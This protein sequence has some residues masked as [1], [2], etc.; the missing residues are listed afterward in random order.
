MPPSLVG[1]DSE[2]V[3]SCEA[4]KAMRSVILLGSALVSLGCSCLPPPVVQHDPWNSGEAPMNRPSAVRDGTTITLRPG[5]ATFKVPQD[6]LKWHRQFGN[7]LHLTHKQL[8]AVARGGGEWD[9]E[10][11]S[12]CN[13]ALPFDRCA[14]HVGEEGWGKEGV[15]YADLQ[16]RVYEL[17]EAPEVVERRIREQG[18]A[19][20]KRFSGH[21]PEVKSDKDSVWRRTVLAFRLWYGDYGGTAHVDFRVRR[22][23]GRTIVFVFMYSN[24]QSH[25]KTIQEILDSFASKQVSP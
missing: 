7:N 11:A 4:G 14:A 20:V 2:D 19:D 23:G 13:A 3:P 21:R 16:V 22:C 17:A 1:P 6:W 25:A 18:A 15:S 8:D 12:V 24:Y 10:Y 5:G 9:T